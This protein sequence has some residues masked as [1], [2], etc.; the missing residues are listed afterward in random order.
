[1]S[2]P[3]PA[4]G[5]PQSLS[6]LLPFLKPYRSR[7]ALAGLF[8]VLAA[9]ATLA[10]PWALRVLIDGG[11]Q[12]GGSAQDKGAQLLALNLD[13]IAVQAIEN[14]LAGGHDFSEP[15]CRKSYGVAL[16]EPLSMKFA[17]G[18]KNTSLRSSSDPAMTSPLSVRPSVSPDTIECPNR[19]AAATARRAQAVVSRMRTK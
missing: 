15:L 19:N 8:L 5:K 14:L 17:A 1:M 12:A 9:V 7:I 3:T 11:L 2:T 16:D 10:F 6:G 13:L 18:W 4:P